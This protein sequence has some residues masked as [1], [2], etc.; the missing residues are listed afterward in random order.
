MH[1]PT[2]TLIALQ[3][4]ADTNGGTRAANTQGYDASVEYIAG[5]LS[6]AGFDVET[7]EFAY[8]EQ[9]VDA[10]AFTVGDTA[11]EVLTMEF[12]PQTRRA[13]SPA[14]WPSYRKTKTRRPAV[15]QQTSPRS[16]TTGRSR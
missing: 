10:E 12:S 7:P 6:E 14:R 13:G 5:K 9:V 1:R 4:I 3:R 2:G 15:K 11:Y 16:R 8:Q